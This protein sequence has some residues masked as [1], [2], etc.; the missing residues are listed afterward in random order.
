M[1]R[2]MIQLLLLWLLSGLTF[3]LAFGLVARTG[4]RR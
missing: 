4:E 2:P 1:I 3:A